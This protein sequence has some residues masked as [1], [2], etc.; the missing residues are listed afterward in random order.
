MKIPL[1]DSLLLIEEVFNALT[2]A[3]AL[4]IKLP[5]D[6]GYVYGGMGRKV[7]YIA[8]F[9]SKEELLDILLRLLKNG[10]NNE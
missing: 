1:N 8:R 2:P 9:S 5:A 3:N 10:R 7:H 6:T 4:K